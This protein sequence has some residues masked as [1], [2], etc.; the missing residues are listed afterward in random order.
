M[1]L[2][3]A[4]SARRDFDAAIAYLSERS[5]AAADRIGERILA[6]T[7]LLEDFPEIAPVSRHR[8][9]RQMVVMRTP[10][11]VIYRVHDGQVE[12]R[13]VVHGRQK[14]RR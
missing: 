7:S 6:A 2:V 11:L 13:A 5:P 4:D 10:Y 12:V 8:G 14:R 3:W 9:L 1:R